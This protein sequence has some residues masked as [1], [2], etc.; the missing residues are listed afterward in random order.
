MAPQKGLFS[1]ENLVHAIAGATG[2]VVGMTVFY[3]LDTVR[4]RLQLEEG[5][6]AKNTLA[7]LKDLINEEGFETL[8]RGAVPV[9]QSI[10]ASNFVYFYSFHG[11]KS[12][13]GS[14]SNQSAAKDLLLASIAGVINVLSTT[15]LW[16]VNTRLK[17]S[18]VGH[19]KNQKP[20]Y[21]GLWD[22]LCKIIKTEG[23]SR[24]WSGTVP[25]LILVSNPAIHFMV[26][27]TLKR[28]ILEG[29]KPSEVSPMTFFAVGATA[30]AIATFLTYPLQLV[31]TKMRH[32]HKYPDLRQDAGTLE[33]TAYIIRKY[34]FQG[35]YKGMEA[36]VIQ[37]ILT[38]AL[39]FM[40]YEQIVAFVFKLLLRNSHLTV[41]KK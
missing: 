28:H 17:M 36:K 23:V 18:G 24:L 6:K 9:L 35:L 19:G 5:R 7:V 33:L 8:Y 27:E 13:T 16:V 31:Q 26:Y 1:Y 41:R 30:K 34:G 25:S 4:S 11:L 39:M 21:Q 40:T 38:A 3:P 15:P 20:E 14:S 37:T 10:C 12:V 29:R 32:G 22:G 2:S